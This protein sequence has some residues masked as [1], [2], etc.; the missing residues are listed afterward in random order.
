[1]L[2]N[3]T[4][5]P[6][7]AYLL[8]ALL[9]RYERRYTARSDNTAHQ[10]LRFDLQAA[11]LPDY[12]SQIDPMPRQITN[13]QL[14]ALEHLGWVKLDWLPGETGHLLAIVKDAGRVIGLVHKD[15][16]AI[17]CRTAVSPIQRHGGVVGRQHWHQYSE[18]LL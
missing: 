6:A 17:A 3:F 10:A 16:E 7:V 5:S 1:M 14:S 15:V 11:H 2:P 18:S 13:E 8:H 12:H 9:D 4:P